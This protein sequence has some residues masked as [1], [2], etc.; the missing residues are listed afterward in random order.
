[1]ASAV[2]AAASPP[3]P[4]LDPITESNSVFFLCD[5][6]ETFRGKIIGYEPLIHTA[7]FLAKVSF[8]IA[9]SRAPA[10]QSPASILSQPSLDL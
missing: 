4:V 8:E 9:G 5:I 1:M 10:A 3:L 7:A 2:A 6:Q